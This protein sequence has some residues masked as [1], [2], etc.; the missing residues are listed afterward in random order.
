MLR[1]PLPWPSADVVDAL[2]EKS[3]GY[4][5]YAST[6]IKFVDDKDFRPTDQLAIVLNPSS[7]YDALPYA[8]LDRL[9]FQILSQ[10]PER[11]HPRLLAIL[12]AIF[13][14]DSES[15]VAISRRL[16]QLFDLEDGDVRLALS[17]LHSVLYIPPKSYA[18]TYSITAIHASFGG[19]LLGESRSSIFHL[20]AQARIDVARALLR[21][22]SHPLLD[23]IVLSVSQ[24]H[25]TGRL[26]LQVGICPKSGRRRNEQ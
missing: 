6:V 2:V 7:K 24:P 19:F 8:P 22:Y 26:R 9:Y 10:V 11:S 5:I 3:S 4:F 17:R 1:V 25:G 15:Y 18:F 20:G 23:G 14:F 13:T 12:A 21:V 16:E